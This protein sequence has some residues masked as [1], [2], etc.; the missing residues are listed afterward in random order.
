MSAF[1]LKHVKTGDFVFLRRFRM[2]RFSVLMAILSVCLFS[3]ANAGISAWNCAPDSDGAIETVGDLT[4]D[5]TLLAEGGIPAYELS[6][7]VTQNWGP[8]HM[9]GDFTTDTQT[10]PIVYLVEDVDNQTGFSWTGYEF[11]VFMDKTF[12]I[13]AAFMPTGWSSDLSIV[14][15]DQPWP[16]NPGVTGYMG[17]VTFT[18]MDPMYNID[19]GEIGTFG[20]RM[21]FDG[22]ASFCTEQTPI[23]EPATMALLGLGGLALLRRK[24]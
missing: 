20:V 11:K 4:W 17:V 23:P 2:K 8:A 5:D 7:D 21:Q 6:M 1:P 18:A 19:P 24:K 15:A 10:D 12:T 13:S 9:E 14:L 3:T 16:H 22:S